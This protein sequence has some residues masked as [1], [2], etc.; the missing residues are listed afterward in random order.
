MASVRKLV[1][2]WGEKSRKGKGS[3]LAT[4]LTDQLQGQYAVRH[5]PLD[6]VVASGCVIIASKKVGL[7]GGGRVLK[8]KFAASP[9][10]SLACSEFQDI[11][12]FPFLLVS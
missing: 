11:F 10:S 1:G 8:E 6:I 3:N 4:P 7:G 12:P 2:G 9:I 5:C